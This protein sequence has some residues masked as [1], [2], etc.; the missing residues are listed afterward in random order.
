MDSIVTQELVLGRSVEWTIG[1]A[2]PGGQTL[3]RHALRRLHLKDLSQSTIILAFPCRSLT[4][5]LKNSAIS[6]R[7]AI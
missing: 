5:N 3:I 4:D 7:D 2:G 6:V 1:V